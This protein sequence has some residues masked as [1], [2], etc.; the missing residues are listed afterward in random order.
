M[1]SM[2]DAKIVLA[3][4]EQRLYDCVSKACDRWFKDVSREIPNSYVR[5]EANVIYNLIATEARNRFGSVS[6]VIVTENHEQ[7]L[8]YIDDAL[9]VRFKKVDP[10]LHTACNS[11][12]RS[13]DLEEGQISIPGLPDLEVVTVGYQLDAASTRLESVYIFHGRVVWSYELMAAASNLVS[14]PITPAPAAKV[15]PISL[16]KPR[17]TPVAKVGSDGDR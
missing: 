6:H 1:I 17:V 5:T 13:F 14:L 3:P 15:V 2:D 7:I 11:T 12:Q 9:V 16:A 10:G 8:L 4:H